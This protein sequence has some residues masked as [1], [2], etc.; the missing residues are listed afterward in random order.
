MIDH[1]KY[2]TASEYA[3]RNREID[4]VVVSINKERYDLEASAPSLRFPCFT[5]YVTS[6]GRLSMSST[7]IINREHVLEIARWLVTTFELDG[8][9]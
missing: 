1:P 3:K 8:K 5:M 2:K 4:A 6:D 7:N 9:L